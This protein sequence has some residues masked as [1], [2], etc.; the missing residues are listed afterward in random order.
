MFLPIDQHIY[1]HKM[2]GWFI[3]IFS[4]F[5]T[6]MHLINIGKKTFIVMS[7]DL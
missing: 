5:H 6:V 4:V 1:F 7:N 2:T 3:F